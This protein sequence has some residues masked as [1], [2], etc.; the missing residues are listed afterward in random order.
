MK[1]DKVDDLKVTDP[2]ISL[3]TDSSLNTSFDTT[4]GKKSDEGV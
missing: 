4:T 2:L 1:L 3:A